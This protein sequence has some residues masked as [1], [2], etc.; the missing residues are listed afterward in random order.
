MEESMKFFVINVIYVLEIEF[1]G[2]GFYG[3]KGVLNF[4]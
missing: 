1:R 4:I 3:V 2:N